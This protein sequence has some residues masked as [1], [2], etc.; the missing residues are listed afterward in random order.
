MRR[1]FTPDNYLTMAFCGGLTMCLLAQVLNVS[2]KG[3]Q[4]VGTLIAW[5]AC[6]IWTVRS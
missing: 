2:G 3:F 1:L 5:I 4:A 6:L